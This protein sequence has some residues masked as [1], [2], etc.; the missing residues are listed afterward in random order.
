MSKL[1]R[2]IS[3]KDLLK[4]FRELGFE[5]VRQRAS[6]V[7]L[8]KDSGSMKQGSQLQQSSLVS[9]SLQTTLVLL[10]WIDC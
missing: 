1:P 8:R 9:F 4:V 6:H 5:V 10:L 7:F 3:G 2:Q